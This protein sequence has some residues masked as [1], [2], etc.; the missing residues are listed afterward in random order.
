MLPDLI[1]I[2]A[3]IIAASPGVIVNI[4][5]AFVFSSSSPNFTHISLSGFAI[6]C[7][8]VTCFPGTYS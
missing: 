8:S 3:L 7:A 2:S 6:K 5:I 1:A 4:P